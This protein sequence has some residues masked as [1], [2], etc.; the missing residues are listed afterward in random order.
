[1]SPQGRLAI[2]QAESK[3]LM[4][5]LHVWFEKQFDEKRVEPNSGLG[6]AITYMMKHWEVLT[7]FLEIPGAPHDNTI[8]E[9][10][11]KKAII[12]RKNSLF[13]KTRKGAFIGDMFMSLIQTCKMA[14]ENSFDHL[15][16]FRKTPWR[17]PQIPKHGCHGISG[18]PYPLLIN[19]PSLIWE[20]ICS[21]LWHPL[22]PQ[23]T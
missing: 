3:P 22:P 18:R 10:A 17:W 7:R 16:A 13:Y 11:L 8:C 12:H 5:D 20:A 21:A 23:N 9:R 15:A 4:H 6:K 14:L 2:H 19:N 1:M